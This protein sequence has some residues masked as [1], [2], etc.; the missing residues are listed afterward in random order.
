MRIIFKIVFAI[1]IILFFSCKHKPAHED[2]LKF[3]V[4]VQLQTK[5]V[6]NLVKSFSPELSKFFKNYSSAN[7]K[8]IHAEEFVAFKNSFFNLIKQIDERSNTVKELKPNS[9][10]MMMKFFAYNVIKNTREL[11][12]YISNFIPANRVAFLSSKGI[13]LKKILIK[14]KYEMLMMDAGFFMKWS[15]KYKLEHHLTQAEL[16]KYVL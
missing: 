8:N 12:V 9:E 3:Y 10:G 13:F 4:T 16:S 11:L 14:T 2:D 5:A 1:F 15:D 7:K 6:T